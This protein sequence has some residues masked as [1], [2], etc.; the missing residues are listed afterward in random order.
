M[1]TV[2]LNTNSS[3]IAQSMVRARRAAGSP[4]MDMVLT[5]VVITDEDGV[6]ETLRTATTLSKEHPS[7]V[8]G[9]IRGSNR[10]RA[11]LDAKVRVGHDSTGE[12]ILLRVSGELTKHAESVV[13]PLLLPDS[14]V[15]VWWPNKAPEIP[16]E[17]AIGRLAQRRLTDAE[18]TASPIRA[19][20]AVAR[21]YAPGDTDLSWTRLTPW[22]ALLAAALDQ[23]SA[24]VT[25]GHLVTGA[26]NPAA[27]L[28]VSWLESR[29]KIRLT[30]QRGDADHISSVTLT[31]AIGDV[32]IERINDSTCNFSVPGAADHHVP[33]GARTHAELLA[34][35]LRRLDNDEIYEETITHMLKELDA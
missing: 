5:L 25:S 19:L 17:D 3:K 35:D 30:V 1:E 2:L 14:P 16:S 31:T 15:V 8:I 10:G 12:S 29:L 27:E 4:A 18:S 32:T 11:N 34:E 22:R 33:L 9:V 24:K 26:G 20:R 7:R 23:T 21:N 6:A 13:L 28:L